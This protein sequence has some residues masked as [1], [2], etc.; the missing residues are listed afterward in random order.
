[1]GGNPESQFAG[2]IFIQ[3]G[4]D[5]CSGMSNRLRRSPTLG[6][7]ELEVNQILRIA[8]DY[9]ADMIAMDP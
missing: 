2:L 8:Q 5:P 3:R 4:T 6:A 7:D 1:M 9:H